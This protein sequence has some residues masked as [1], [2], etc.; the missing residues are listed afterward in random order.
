LLPYVISRGLIRRINVV[1]AKP[2]IF[3]FHPWE[4]DPDQPRVSGPGFKTRFRHYVNLRRVQP[5][6]RRLLRDFKWNRI[7][8]VY[9][10]E[11]A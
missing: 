4:L 10:G 6:M 5:R 7:D 11:V 3:Y 1:D 8:R 9:G 2:A